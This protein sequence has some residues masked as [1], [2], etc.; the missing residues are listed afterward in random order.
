MNERLDEICTA[1]SRIEGK[2][3]ASADQF[4]AHVTE[5]AL[6]AHEVRMLSRQR[7]Y[8]LSGLAVVGAGIGAAVT[9][10]VKRLVGGH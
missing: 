4:A 5:D 10:A 8:F 3:D 7:G 1:L 2:L 9:Y 6:L